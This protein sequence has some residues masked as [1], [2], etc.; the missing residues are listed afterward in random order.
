MSGASRVAIRNAMYNLLLL[1]TPPFKSN[2]KELGVPSNVEDYDMP[3]LYIV[4]PE[5]NVGEAQ[6]YGL[7][8][9]D[10]MIHAVMYLR[11]AGTPSDQVNPIEDQI[12]NLLDAILGQPGSHNSGVFNTM[13]PDGSPKVPGE[14]QTLGGL[15]VDVRV[16][17]R[18]FIDSG[19]IGTLC[20]VEIPFAV[21]TGI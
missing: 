16:H 14:A 1:V 3:A 15:V 9:C 11:K 19:I 4:K 2:G 12:D 10:M 8:R 18:I 21:V 17:G 13:Y 20:V 5:E 6:V 7:Q